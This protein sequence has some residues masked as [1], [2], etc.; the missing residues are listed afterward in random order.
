MN[1]LLHLIKICTQARFGGMHLQRQVRRR[2]QLL[3]KTLGDIVR[4][5]FKRRARERWQGALAG[6]GDQA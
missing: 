1:L 2:L 6:K 4:P 5:A 3:Q